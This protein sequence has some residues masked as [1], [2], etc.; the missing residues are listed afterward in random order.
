MVFILDS[1]H[2]EAGIKIMNVPSSLGVEAPEEFKHR[3][4][5]M[6]PVGEV[7]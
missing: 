3:R 2:L 1:R 5:L 6:K 4:E 7:C